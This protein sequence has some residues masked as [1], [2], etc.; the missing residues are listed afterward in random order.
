[1]KERSRVL[2][3]ENIRGER[4]GRLIDQNCMKC[5]LHMLADL[6]LESS[7]VYEED[8]ETYFLEGTQ[9]F[10]R[11]ESRLF[12]S[13]NSCPDYLKRVE[14]RISEEM[15]RVPNY[16]HSSTKPKLQLI[17]ETELIST[18]AQALIE[19]KTS[20]LGLLLEQSKDRMDDLKRMYELFFRVPSAMRL[21]QDALYE[22][23][24]AAGTSLL[25][26]DTKVKQP[27]EFLRSL[28][29][30]KN[31]YDAVVCCAFQGEKIAQKRL[32]DA[33]E[34]FINL[35][36]R[37]ASCLVIYI[38]E[39]MRSGFKGTTEGE[40]E[41]ELDKIL[42]IFR[43]LHD[44]DIFGML[45]KQH[46]AKRLLNHRSMSSEAERL[47]L[48]KLKG[49][50]GYQYTTKLEGMFSDI[51][52]SRGT[53]EKYNACRKRAPHEYSPSFKIACN[54]DVTMLTAGYW[55]LQCMS[56]CFLPDA[57]KAATELFEEFYLGEHSGRKLTWVTN[58]GS[59][60]LRAT[61]SEDLRHELC[62]STYQMC[63]LVLFNTH[64]PDAGLPF[65]EIARA[66][67]IPKSELKRHLISI[68]TPKHRILLKS[69]KG[70]GIAE[71][72]TFRVNVGFSTK[73]KRVRVPLVAMKEIGARSDWHHDQQ[74]DRVKEDR[75]HLCEATIVR[76]MKARKVITHNEL[77]AEVCVHLQN[78]DEILQIGHTSASSSFFSPAPVHQ[79]ID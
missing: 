60:E 28:L 76:V 42:A 10:Y 18:H 66:T 13:Q 79:K 54:I 74:P 62:V 65:E 47:M 9:A 39:L 51:K 7:S 64:H 69:T 38:D 23:V 36:T 78:I 52:F 5:A 14:R 8:F 22:H 53:T 15:A 33:F 57:A 63:I 19:S 37:C 56:P 50:C 2:L 45:Y 61:L 55:P 58:C 67:Q 3:L 26:D 35:D 30:L 29:A 40:M 73:L 72:S 59:V 68:C 49:E 27:V 21:L 1:M 75:R 25:D 16:L 44:K 17:M 6:G 31:K 46:L 41:S 32:K 12:L 34:S 48:A 20:G 71:S 4:L 77:I 11:N 24:R 43:Y 70:K